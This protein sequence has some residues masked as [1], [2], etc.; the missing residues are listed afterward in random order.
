MDV[1]YAIQTCDR[2]SWQAKTRVCGD[3]RT[4]L[5]KKSLTSLFQSIQYC[6]QQKSDVIHHI[7]I[8]DDHSSADL[9]Q[10]IQECKNSYSTHNI[11]IQTVDLDPATGIR[12]SI[13]ACYCWLRSNGTNLVYQIQ[14]DYIF[15]KKSIYL[16]IDMFY[17]ILG[18]T[19]SHC[20]VSPY[21]DSYHWLTQYRNRTTPR[22]VIVGKDDYWIQIYDI[23]CS[24]L[25]SHQQFIRHW[26]LY[27]TF[28]DLIDN[29]DENLK[30]TGESILENKSL[31]LMLTQRNVLAL[32]PIRSLAHH[33][34]GQRE[35]DP[36]CS[37]KLLW[38]SIVL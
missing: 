14:D 19:G 10:F 26:D 8:I 7:A 28:F 25:T 23:S 18:E 15:D 20:L 35:I 12:N 36:F 4:L 17:Q 37:W 34:Q 3:D 38:D 6:S 13:E 32:V 31:N 27:E 21:H 16:T 30:K 1:H 24:F 33:I 9:K 5:S 11:I 29:Y 22:A 2:Q